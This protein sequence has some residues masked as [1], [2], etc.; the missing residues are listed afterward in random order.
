MSST[1]ELLRRKVARLELKLDR[2]RGYLALEGRDL[3]DV[4]ADWR[5]K[6]EDE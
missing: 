3:D 4:T 5:F 2:V 1:E 6:N